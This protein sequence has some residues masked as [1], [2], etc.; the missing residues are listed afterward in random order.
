[1]QKCN[2]TTL[3]ITTSTQLTLKAVCKC[4]DYAKYKGGVNVLFAKR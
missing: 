3:S 4:I 1:M 2:R